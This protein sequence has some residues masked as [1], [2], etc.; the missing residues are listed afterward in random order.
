MASTQDHLSIED[1]KNDIAILKD[2]GM[3]LVLETNAVNFGL[4]SENEQLAIISA[5]ASL[6]NSLSFPIQIL[7]RSKRL[8]VT[9]YLQFLETAQKS[10][11]NPLLSR[12]MNSYRSFI[13]K[14]VR[15]N[16]VLDKQFFIIIN[17]SALELGITK[18]VEGHF[19]KGITILLPR[20]D[21]IIRQ[22]WR[23]G[24]RATQLN[25]EQLTRLFYDIY[26]PPNK[27]VLQQKIE[28]AIKAVEA[29]QIKQAAPVQQE[30]TS[31][32]PI[33]I[34][35][36]IQQPVQVLTNQIQPQTSNLIIP[37]VVEE[38]P[39]DYTTI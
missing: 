7:I 18:N 26:N 14:T 35:K 8:D 2:G 19:D 1:I 31:P 10:Q 6:I 27:L 3:A 37:F 32:Q 25:N 22:L 15:E 4:L 38:L 34:P 11:T 12:M 23:T 33:Q 16:N 5:F 28:S 21:H 24:L 36:P 30:P 29:Q 13:E 9:N 20:R 17:V 39:D